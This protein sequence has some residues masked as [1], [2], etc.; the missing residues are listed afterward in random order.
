MKY[1]DFNC[2][3]LPLVLIR[4]NP[5]KPT[6]EQYHDELF[7]PLEDLCSRFDKMIWVVD[8]RNV[9]LLSSEHRILANKWVKAHSATIQQKVTVAFYTH[10]SFWTELMVKGI[11]VMIK[12]PIPFH[13]CADLSAVK[14]LLKEEYQIEIPEIVSPNT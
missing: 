7:R 2:S 8:A 1:A 6:V 14:I 10:C 11:L 13:L 12:T 4:I 3:Q 5:V 9:T